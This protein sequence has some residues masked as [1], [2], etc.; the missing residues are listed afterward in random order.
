MVMIFDFF[1]THRKDVNKPTNE[2]FVFF[3]ESVTRKISV[4]LYNFCTEFDAFE[5]FFYLDFLLE[6]FL[7]PLL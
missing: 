2:N 4:T 5:L 6:Y 1:R 3:F 7:H